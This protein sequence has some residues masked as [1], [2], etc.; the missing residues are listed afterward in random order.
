MKWEP[1]VYRIRR[2][3]SRSLWQRT[4]QCEWDGCTF[5]A[6]GY[7]RDRC[8]RKATRWETWQTAGYPLGITAVEWNAERLRWWIGSRLGLRP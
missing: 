6:R 2:P 4:Y 1:D 3:D 8:R 5:A 7:T